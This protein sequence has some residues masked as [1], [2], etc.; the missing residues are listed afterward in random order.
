MGGSAAAAFELGLS[1]TFGANALMPWKEWFGQGNQA[2]I[3][4]GKRP[5][6]CGGVALAA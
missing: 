2:R 5:A 3:G 6:Q 1:G 4:N